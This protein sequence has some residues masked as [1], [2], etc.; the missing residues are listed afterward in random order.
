MFD[1][2]KLAILL[3]ILLLSLF[4]LPAYSATW[5]DI[6]PSVDN[7]VNSVVASGYLPHLDIKKNTAF[8]SYSAILYKSGNPSS[9]PATYLGKFHFYPMG[10]G[11][12]PCTYSA[13]YFVSYYVSYYANG[14]H[15]PDPFTFSID[16]NYI[17]G[18][19]PCYGHEIQLYFEGY[20]GQT[21]Y[22]DPLTVVSGYK[23]C[24]SQPVYDVNIPFNSFK[25]YRS[26]SDFDYINNYVLVA[27]WE[28]SINIPTTNTCCNVQ[29]SYSS[30]PP[31]VT[32]VTIPCDCY[33]KY[34]GI[35]GWDV[36]SGPTCDPP[37]YECTYILIYN[38]NGISLRS[39]Y[40]IIDTQG[41]CGNSGSDAGEPSCDTNAP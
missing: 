2:A 6:K 5:A 30:T 24:S 40:F 14:S 8:N 9:L 25:F 1:K 12:N 18:P 19:Y 37:A 35:P 36:Q 11:T 15:S 17:C 20:N 31:T 23:K 4:S 41:P 28:F 21:V 7:A 38:A 22:P 10:Y 29:I 27:S 32:Q 3:A 34:M 39:G 13:N 33:E 16:W 26:Q